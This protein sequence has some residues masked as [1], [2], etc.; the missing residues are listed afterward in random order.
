MRLKDFGA[1]E[2]VIFRSALKRFVNFIAG[3]TFVWRNRPLYGYRVKILARPESSS[4]LFRQ[5]AAISTF[6][7]EPN[8]EEFESYERA[9]ALSSCL[10]LLPWITQLRLEE[11]CKLSQVSNPCIPAMRPNRIHL[12]ILLIHRKLFRGFHGV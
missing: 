2:S 4:R 1:S 7:V 10:R 5:I 9:N 11:C 3:T 8:P 12:Y 6:N